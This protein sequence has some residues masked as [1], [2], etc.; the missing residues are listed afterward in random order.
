MPK[1]DSHMLIILIFVLALTCINA[2]IV[3][4]AYPG[5]LLDKVKFVKTSGGN[6]QFSDTIKTTALTSLCMGIFILLGFV[7][8]YNK[9][10]KMH[11][12]GDEDEDDE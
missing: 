11:S 3:T 7:L 2:I 5:I 10:S 1:K 4:A 12:G 6:V 8:F 9:I